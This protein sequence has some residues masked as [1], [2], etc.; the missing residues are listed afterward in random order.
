MGPS[1]AVPHPAAR[2]P[3]RSP[4]CCGRPPCPVSCRLASRYR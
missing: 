1:F 3:S 4:C 2:T